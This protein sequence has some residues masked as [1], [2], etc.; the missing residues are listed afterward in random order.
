[1]SELADLFATD[2]LKLTRDNRKV[3]IEHMRASRQQFMLGNKSAGAPAKA[4]KE[5]KVKGEKKAL[6]LDDLG[7]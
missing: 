1:M 6:N 5:P 7:I 3:I 4:P 2:P